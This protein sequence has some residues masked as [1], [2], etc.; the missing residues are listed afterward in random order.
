MQSRWHLLLLYRAT[1]FLLWVTEAL[2]TV[3]ACTG[4]RQ[5]GPDALTGDNK[6]HVRAGPRLISRWPTQHELNY[7][8]GV[9]WFG[10]VLFF[11]GSGRRWWFGLL[12]FYLMLLCLGIFYLIFFLTYHCFWFCVFI[13]F[14]YVCAYICVSLCYFGLFCFNRV[15]FYLPF[16]F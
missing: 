5:V 9:F 7:I 6:P 8:F 14:I 10:F 16:F 13:I 15:H 12:W 1:V 4:L 2:Q 11:S 3:A